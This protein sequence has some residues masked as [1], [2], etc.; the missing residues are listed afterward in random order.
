[1]LTDQVSSRLNHFIGINDNLTR[2]RY[3]RQPAHNDR[4]IF[5]PTSS[6]TIWM[7]LLDIERHLIVYENDTRVGVDENHHFFF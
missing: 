3:V 7:F 6:A 1:M 5:L 2:Y 4:S